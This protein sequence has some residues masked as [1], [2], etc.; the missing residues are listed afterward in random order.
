ME[1]RKIGLI[2]DDELLEKVEKSIVPLLSKANEVAMFPYSE[3]RNLDCSDL[4]FLLVYLSDAQLHELIEDLIGNPVKLGF[5]PHPDMKEA[6]QGFGVSTSLEDNIR[7]LLQDREAFQVDVLLANEK[8]ILNQLVIG[9]TFS[10]L[11]T[12]SLESSWFKRFNRKIANFFRVFQRVSLQKFKISWEE[13]AKEEN[14][15]ELETAALGMIVVQHGKS[16]LL[17]RRYIEESYANDG[18]FHTLIHAPKSILEILKFAIQGIFR[19][20]K[21][22]RLPDYVA[23]I[24]TDKLIVK[25][26]SPISYNLDNTLLSSKELHL[27]VKPNALRIIPGEFLQVNTVKDS[28]KIFK[29]NQLPKGELKQ[30]LLK[31]YLPF[32]NHATTEEFKWLFTALRENSKVSSS[33]LVLMALSTMIAAFG[34][35]GDS[36]PVIIGAMILAPLMS[37]I[38]SLA[39]GV[40]RQDSSLIKDS[41]FTILMGLLVGYSFAILITW[42]TPLQ[43]PNQEILARIRPN[44]L[45]LGVAAASGVAGAYAHAKKEVAKTLAGVAI[46]VA[47]VPPLAVSGI[48]LGWADW[49][50]FFGALLLLGTNL[51]GMVLAG[52][53]TFLV[54][55]FSP[56]HLA[57]KGLLISLILVLI[58]STPLG[59]GFSRMVKENKL[60]QTLSGREIEMGKLR[61]VSIIQMNPMRISLTLV[62]DSPLDFEELEAAKREIEQLVGSEVE[63]ELTLAIRF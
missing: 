17:S 8:P 38:I 3:L 49:Q 6:R 20:N 28:A 7:Y 30:E 31:G 19:N 63:L 10:M 39:M 40:L 22:Q 56:F 14:S 13:T 51:A 35:F 36:S 45:D 42:L 60:V 43:T 33:Y 26:D 52:A 58:I 21:N 34:L 16:S 47:L 62:S 27:E 57:K 54:L 15:K 50:I 61:N 1:G 29:V 25:S 2:Y 32:T 9:K 53:L 11:S 37:P 41:I 44:L 18:L 46:A 59:F 4:Q 5:L 48:G 55:G 23:H 24:K 12:P